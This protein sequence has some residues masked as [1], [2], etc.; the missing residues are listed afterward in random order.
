MFAWLPRLA[1]PGSCRGKARGLCDDQKRLEVIRRRW[2]RRYRHLRD[3]HALV[4]WGLAAFAAEVAF[5]L[6]H[7]L[8]EKYEWGHLSLIG[9]CLPAAAGFAVAIVVHQFGFGQRSAR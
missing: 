4:R 8:F 1:E 2:H 6:G 9:A 7:V 5:P 3:Y